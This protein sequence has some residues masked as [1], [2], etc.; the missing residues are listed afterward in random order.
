M[1]HQVNARSLRAHIRAVVAAARDSRE[2]YAGLITRLPGPARASGENLADSIA[3]QRAGGDLRHSLE[4][5]NLSIGDSPVAV[6][7]DL[8]R[9]WGLV[10]ES[11][12]GGGVFGG[13]VLGSTLSREAGRRLLRR[14]ALGSLGVS[15]RG[16]R[17][18]VTAPDDAADDPAVLRALLAEGVSLLRINCA[19]GDEDAW[20]K[21]V[22][23]LRQAQ[24]I[25]GARCRVMMDLAGP[26]V[27]TSGV[28]SLRGGPPGVGV[29]DRFLLLGERVRVPESVRSGCAAAVTITE[30]S[31]LTDI[32]T[33]ERVL[34][35]DGKIGAR[36]RRRDAGWAELVVEQARGKGGK[37]RPERSLNFPESDLRLSGL[38]GKD[39]EDILHAATMADLVGLS[40]VKHPEH[41]AEARELLHTAG[42]VA[43]VLKVE[44]RAALRRLDRL[45]FETLRARNAAVLI[46]RGD[47][48]AECGF[49]V[50]PRIQHHVARMAHAAHIP[51]ILATQVLE[52]MV[53]TGLPSRAEMGDLAYASGIECLLLNKG[54]FVRESARFLRGWLA[55]QADE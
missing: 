50:L 12:S 48:A 14:R 13:T 47:L 55:R 38:T 7:D 41:V 18:M 25:T 45:L 53:R 37:I 1:P 43:I 46:A 28:K 44:N 32:Q 33:G 54:P 5:L 40:F 4:G 23:R 27:R 15:A 11:G 34:I 2:E 26:K 30:P 3:L 22:G 35:D 10:S 8:R 31:V 21:I 20:R 29:G 19:R 52:R 6:A 16:R 51:V 42:R 36:V 39:R 17:I 24:R 49:E 9:L